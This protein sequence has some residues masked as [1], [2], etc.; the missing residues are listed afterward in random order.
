M[1]ARVPAKLGSCSDKKVPKS[2][3]L[4]VDPCA[5]HY[6]RLGGGVLNVYTNTMEYGDAMPRQKLHF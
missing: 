1:G 2:D 4:I 3:E 6:L 5:M